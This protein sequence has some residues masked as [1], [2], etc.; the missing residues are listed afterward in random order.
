M[1]PSLNPPLNLLVIENLP[2][3]FRLLERHLHQQ[4]LAARCHRV[5]T[6]AELQAAAAREGWDAV[7]SEHRL[8]DLEFKDILG[9]LQTSHPDLPLILISGGIGEETV[10][11]LLQSGV[12]DFVHKDNL[13]RLVP[14]LERSLRGAAD[15]RARRAVAAELRASEERYRSLFENMLNG[16]AYCRMIFAG[17]QPQ[18]FIYLA[19]NQAFTA[20]TE[21]QDVVGRRVSEVIPGIR[22]ADPR[23]FE[24]YGRVARTGVPERFETHVEALR[25][26][27][28]VAVY[29]PAPD[30]FVAVFDVITGRKAAEQALQDNAARFSIIFHHSPLGIVMTRLSDGMIVDANAAFA[31]LH[32]YRLDDVIGHSSH[33]LQLWADPAQR[34]ALAAQ[35]LSRGTCQDLEIKARKKNG[36]IRDLLVSVDLIELAGEQF[37]LG[38]ARDIT[39][40]KRSAEAHARLAT[41]V[42]QAVETIVITDLDGAILYANPAFEKT[43]GYTC[44]EVLGRNPRL[45]KSGRHDAEFYRRMWETLQR[46]EVWH[47]HFINRRKDGALYEEEASIS[48]VRDAAGRW[49]NY[50]AVKRDVTHEVQLESRFRQ[51]Q[52]MEA[53]GTLAGGI[54]HDFNNIL[55]AM[56]GY[57]YLLQQDTEGN[58]PAQDSLR[59]ILQ[60]ANRAKDLVLQ[61]LTFS[62]QREQQRTVIRLDPVIKEA[63]KFL[64]ASLPADIKVEL[65][66][67]AEAPHVLADPTQIYQV[68][69][70][71]ATNS[72]HAMEGR[73]GRLSVKLDSFQ[74]DEAFLQAH[75]E[76]RPVQYARLT[77]ADT[78]D[79]MD[80]QTLEHIFEPFFTTKPVGKGTGLGLSVV[81][82][83]VQSHEGI[84]TVVSQPGRGTTFSLYFPAK[85]HE[86]SLPAAAA[87]PLPPGRG[88]HLLLLDD[89][90]VLTTMYQRMLSGLHYQVS[91]SNH[92]PE[93]LGWCAENP[94]R[95]DLVITDLTM[96][97]INGLDVA[98][99]L[100]ALRP[101]LP[102]ILLSGFNSALTDQ[103][104]REAGVGELL[105][106]P[107]TMADLAAAV[108]RVLAPAA[109][110]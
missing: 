7:L 87:A 75:P 14:A 54:A 28:D 1:S 67:A 33:E 41:A 6:L 59:E 2:E 35:L 77:V 97:E 22:E 26:W 110:A 25:N 73:P 69:I 15:R 31:E 102:V 85:D 96:P 63:A 93:G 27:F 23:L 50:V 48:P 57:C 89:E 104:W 82:G 61:I 5:A 80:S 58:L 100:R 55:A 19:V 38:L 56:F 68:T 70:N 76:G 4:G 17:D 105:V 10:V 18:D 99:R 29:S 65:S 3:D 49:V 32:G 11:E 88:Q 109:P 108:S 8:P 51:A 9:V 71:L 16:F 83:I 39:E 43:S 21:L 20:L 79:G 81:H 12:W 62:R 34:E 84:I 90:P 86:T 52:K 45:L 46:G 13:A 94:A 30:H 37:T 92:A 103:Q 64:R 44:A 101:D 42:E 91:V 74:P 36:E 40:R 72:L 78:G 98:R 24:I 53:I 47:G 66:L 107:V 60:A 106:K 95:F